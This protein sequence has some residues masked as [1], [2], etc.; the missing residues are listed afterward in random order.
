MITIKNL[1]FILWKFLHMSKFL[2]NVLKI[3]GGG[4]MPQMPPPLDARLLAIV[5]FPYVGVGWAKRFQHCRGPIWSYYTFTKCLCVRQASP[6]WWPQNKLA[7]IEENLIDLDWFP[8]LTW[9]Y[10]FQPLFTDLRYCA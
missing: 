4:Q 8:R 2:W 3:L 1:I 7:I 5:T 9:E 6:Q 10:H